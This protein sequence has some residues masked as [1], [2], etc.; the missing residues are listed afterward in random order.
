MQRVGVLVARKPRLPLRVILGLC[1][2][3]VSLFIL[4][5]PGEMI[6]PA[7]ALMPVFPRMGGCANFLAPVVFL[8]FFALGVIISLVLVVVG[9][10]A[11]VLTAKRVRG[12]LT[13]A[14]VVN[15]V[16]AMLLLVTPLSAAGSSTLDQGT[17]AL[18]TLAAVCA[19]FP[20]A[21]TILLLAPA[22]HGSS[23]R[24]VATLIATGLLLLPG[25]AGLTVLGLDL[26]GAAVF[27][28]SSTTPVS[29][30]AHC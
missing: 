18:Y 28:A 13:T 5:F 12:G 21:G 22:L 30:T 3:G 9:I 20:L 8:A 17:L 24:Y 11:I 6:L 23:R 15:A 19:V 25:A 10:T 26:G 29:Q 2:T 14:V 16:V 1:A 7:F 4:V 27:P